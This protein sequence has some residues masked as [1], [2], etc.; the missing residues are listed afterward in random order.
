MVLVLALGFSCKKKET[1]EPAPQADQPTPQADQ[2]TPSAEPPQAAVPSQPW[3]FEMGI[4]K[5]DGRSATVVTYIDGKKRRMDNF[6]GVG[7]DKKLQ[8]ITISTAEG[9]YVLTVADKTG[10]KMPPDESA[11]QEEAPPAVNKWDQMMIEIGKTPGTNIAEKGTE[12]FE[13]ADYKVYRLKGATPN[14]T[15]DYFVDSAGVVRR[16]VRSDQTGKVMEDARINLKIGAL[17]GDTFNLPS[18]YKISEMGKMQ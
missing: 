11:Q 1:P 2:P 10:M 4:V 8:T 12:K 13:G 9:L 17:P 6:E 15:L 7:K 18:D 5:S 3:M 16:V 14:E